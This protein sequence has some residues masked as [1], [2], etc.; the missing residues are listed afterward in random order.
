MQ[1]VCIVRECSAEAR[2]FIRTSKCPGETFES[3]TYH[4]S[5]VY[6]KVCDVYGGKVSI[7]TSF[8]LHVK[9]EHHAIGSR[10]GRH[11]LAG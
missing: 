9:A 8:G 1:T 5:G 7:S 6:V 11:E 3:C 2:H 10:Q 4:A